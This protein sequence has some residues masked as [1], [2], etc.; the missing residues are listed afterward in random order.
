MKSLV[1]MLL[2]TLLAAPTLNARPGEQH[3]FTP[4][5][6]YV[7][8]V[9]D[10]DGTFPQ[11]QKAAVDTIWIATWN[12]EGCD[13]SGWVRSDNRILND[14][15][16]YWSVNS[17]F[18]GLA[19]ILGEAAALGH[20][21]LCWEQPDGYDNAWYQGICIHYLGDSYLSFDYLLDSEGGFDFLQ[22]ETDSACSSFS[23]VN[24]DVNPSGNA[25]TFRDLV[26]ENS[27]FDTVTARVD[28]LALFGYASGD[29]HC[30]YIAF[31]ADGSH[32]PADGRQPSALGVAAVVDNVLLEG[33]ITRFEDFS[34][35]TPTA[36][37]NFVNLQDSTP[38]GAWARIYNYITDNDHCTENQTCAWLATDN[39]TPTFANDPSMAF[40]PGS[41]VIKNWLDEVLVGPWVSLGS[42][43]TATSTF[44]Q[45]NRFP[46]N[47]FSTSRAV[48]NWSIRGKL[49]VANTDTT[50]PGDSIDCISQ[51]GHAFQ[52]NSLSAFSWFN[53]TWD[54]TRDFDPAS[55]DIQVRFRES[56]WQWIA[57]ASAPSPF[58]PGPGPFWDR[59]RLGRQVLTGPVID[60]GIDARFQAQ[61][62][63]PNDPA[64]PSGPSYAQAADGDIF[65]TTAFSRSAGFGES[66][67]FLIIG[68]SITVD[69]EDVLGNGSLTVEVYASIVAG[70]HTGKS[71]APFP[72]GL[73]G[74]F[75]VPA[76]SSYTTWGTLVEDRYF[77]DLDDT[78]FR[79]GDVLRYV[80]Y[81]TDGAG[82][83][84]SNPAGLTAPPTSV[85]QAEVAT[86]GLFEVNFLPTIN[87]DSGYLAR[88]QADT[89]GDLD[90]T[91]TE[92][93]NS[94]QAN[95]ILYYENINSRRLSGDA[96][97]TS[98]MYTLDKLGYRDKYDV[99]DHTGLGSHTNNHLGARLSPEQARNYSLL[100]YDAGNRGP[101]AP[102]LP[103]GMDG[104]AEKVDMISW[105]QAWN[106]LSGGVN[107]EHTLW[108]LGSN[109][110][111]EKPL[112]PL[113]TVDMAAVFTSDNQGQDVNPDVFA[114]AN[115]VTHTACLM[116]HG[117][118]ATAKFAL[119]GGCPVVRDY[120][121]LAAS[122]TGVVTHRYGKGSAG[123]PGAIVMHANAAG[124]TTILSS[125]P[126]F[127]IR[128][129]SGQA[130]TTA[131]EDLLST[132]L[133]C[134]LPANCQEVPD[135]TD[136]DDQNAIA[137]PAHTALHQNTPNP[138]NPMTTIHFD[139]ARDAHVSLQVFDVTGRL[140]RTLKSSVMQAGFDRQVIWNGRD[141]AGKRVSSGV[142]FYRLAAGEYQATRKLVVMK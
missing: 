10:V 82:G 5:P 45:F 87:W 3:E 33:G 4:S 46:G 125:F 49:K 93:A 88:I 48:Q 110:M 60:E 128:S 58:T 9:G 140:V 126:W 65:G 15:N 75:V 120:D 83:V 117:V 132:I 69:V 21:D 127:D 22:V 119:A 133:S 16:V 53:L 6:G 100:I 18:N 86:G 107:Q 19:N 50:A 52:W 38:F 64:F 23:Q 44:I 123:N 34:S 130:P 90:P 11:V 17:N 121:D 131:D 122:G 104:D 70:P 94:S 129:A 39:T 30:A 77:V 81:T 43:P 72:V 112:S 108:I 71:P 92:L 66:Y 98:F 97:R 63:A 29:T 138:F 114:T 74:F 61:D 25:L 135:V 40:G 111:E 20:H 42:T 67:A 26:W 2:L 62:A 85:A 59:V 14:G 84:T 113:L 80:W 37:F 109:V 41:Y 76:D 36:S 137:L 95:C 51:W 141:D 73:N 35:F 115:F 101:G 31:L 102:I 56:D 79:G 27:G 99:Y 24:Y 55:T 32:S 12:F 142:Y 96:N 68:D 118:G 116:S 54:A 136:V 105:F 1:W 106:N 8:V 78:Y 28:S 57:G 7:D 89:H 139:L 134:A 91:P 47:F 13:D 124:F 103:D